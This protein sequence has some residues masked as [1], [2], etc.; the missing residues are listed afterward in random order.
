[1]SAA[2][3][4]LVALLAWDGSTDEKIVAGHIDALRR[5]PPAEAGRAL[6]A[7]L[8]EQAP[9]YQGR[10]PNEAARLRGHVFA[11]LA[12]TGAPAEALPFLIAELQYGHR[13]SL[14][15]AAARAAGT[16][17]RAA[18]PAVPA[19]VR[20][21]AS[22]TF[23]DD[24]VCL[25][26]SD[27]SAPCSDPTTARLEA[28]RTLGRIGPDARAALPALRALAKSEPDGAASTMLALREEAHRAVASIEQPAV[29]VLSDLPDFASSWLPPADRSP[30]PFAGMSFTAH[31]G[32]RHTSAGLTGA[33]LALTFAYTRCDNPNKCPVTIASMARL[34]R[35]LRETGLA[36]KTRIAIVTLD[37]DFDDSARLSA[38]GNFHGLELGDRALMLRPSAADLERLERDLRVPVGRGAGQING[39]GVVLYLFDA[40]GRYVRQYSGAGWMDDHVVADLKKLTSGL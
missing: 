15:A 13:P 11:A 35:S 16:L 24:Q 25:D 39:H 2:A 7:L 40:N 34:Q 5:E 18:A 31:D 8:P 28:V 36:A 3:L 14:L 20:I 37:P 4:V 32:R 27:A 23:H 19:L 33:P 30:S 17:E 12:D 21:L 26:G 22:A 29:P 9:L 6:A 38:S 10:G 1:M